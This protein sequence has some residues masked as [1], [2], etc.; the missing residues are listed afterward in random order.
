MI[1]ATVVVITAVALGVATAYAQEWLPQQIGSLANSA[2]PW[3]LVAFAL[4][5][6]A[7]IGWLA[8]LFGS[9]ALLGLLGGY[10]LGAGI[11]GDASSNTTIVFWGAAALLAGPLLG[12]S[13]HWVKAG[14]DLPAATGAG[15][16][17]GVLL[18]EGIYGLMYIADST[19]PPYWWGEIVVGLM[20][21]VVIAWWRVHGIRA[22]ALFVGATVLTAVALVLVYRWAPLSLL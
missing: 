18:G 6:L 19:Y 21:L 7:T 2:G 12:L 8:S 9:A 13:A 14:R 16:V 3:V 22:I 1:R 5:L 17:C 4:S 15:V 10:V 20:L 11:R